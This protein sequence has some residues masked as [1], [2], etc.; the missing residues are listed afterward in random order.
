LGR[1]GDR[2]EKEV[3]EVLLL[4]AFKAPNGLLC[5]DVPLRNYSLSHS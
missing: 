5:D 3:E 4:E 1:E 2:E